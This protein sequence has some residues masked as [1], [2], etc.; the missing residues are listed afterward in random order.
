V[1]NGNNVVVTGNGNGDYISAG[2]GDNL[3][4]A[5]TGAHTVQLGKGSNILIDGAVTL[6]RS[7]DSL[8]QVLD[9]W[10]ANG[11]APSNVDDIRARLLVSY[12]TSNANYLAAGT[13]LD[14]FWDTFAQDTTTRKS[15]DLLN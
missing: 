6:V 7:G 13:G 3:V 8:R 5:G 14:W 15:T 12:N 1:G 2:S 4:V 9:D 11:A 10:M